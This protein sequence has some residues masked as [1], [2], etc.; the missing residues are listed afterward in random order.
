[1][2]RRV[3]PSA[4][5]FVPKIL[6]EEEF[7]KE[8]TALRDIYPTFNIRY[9][10]EP[11]PYNYVSGIIYPLHRNIPVDVVA[12]NMLKDK[13]FKTNDIGNFW[14]CDLDLEPVQIQECSELYE[15]QAFEVV[16]GSDTPQVFLTKPLVDL[17]YFPKLLHYYPRPHPNHQLES[18]KYPKEEACVTPHQDK[19]WVH[20]HDLV[21]GLVPHIVRYVAAL[22][23]WAF[24]GIGSW[25]TLEAPHTALDAIFQIDPEEPCNCGRKNHRFGDCCL[26]EYQKRFREQLRLGQ[27]Q[28]PW[29][30][31]NHPA[32]KTRG[33]KK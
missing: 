22:R 25:P 4:P 7:S 27:I 8:I 19:T 15:G 3:N 12:A 6:T 2:R 13:D 20:E 16:F 21:S 32:K 18:D 31:G 5:F 11:Q 10:R 28:Q 24:G 26:P 33:R 9:R 23:L 30:T 17:R 14:P 1:M 29:N